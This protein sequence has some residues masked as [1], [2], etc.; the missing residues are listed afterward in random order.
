[1][2]SPTAEQQRRGPWSQPED[3][4][5]MDLVEQ[6]GPSNWVKISHELH[7]RT[8]KQCRER[9]HQNLKP[10]LNHDPI[11]PAEGEMIEQMVATM[12]KRWAEIARR[13]HN[14]S[15]NAVKNWWNGSQNRR[16]RHDQRSKRHS[17]YEPNDSYGYTRMPPT[18]STGQA[19]PHHH[20]HHHHHQQQPY[21]YGGGNNN[22]AATLPSPTE[23]WF[24]NREYPAQRP[25]SSQ[26][27]QGESLSPTGDADVALSEAGSYY[28]GSP[29]SY[30]SP[31]SHTSDAQ[32]PPFSKSF[33]QPIYPRDGERDYSQQ[34]PPLRDA[35][36]RGKQ[37]TQQLITAP[38]SPSSASYSQHVPRTYTMA[39]GG[40][41]SPVANVKTDP[42]LKLAAI[43]Q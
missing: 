9:Y 26:W 17:S 14:R 31:T 15:D 43:L 33:H 8:P 1:M 3:T 27:R 5:L 21:P 30:N 10:S 13:L 34:L 6:I 18:L 39:S 7:T 23:S 22:T 2:N 25:Y 36:D 35:L 38:S 24:S 4:L 29:V 40:P 28:S 16:R 19:S 20:H 32:L 37:L 11:T 41:P 42:R 12:G